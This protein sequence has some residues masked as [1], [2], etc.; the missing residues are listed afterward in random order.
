[1]VANY[2][3]ASQER[4]AFVGKQVSFQKGVVFMGKVRVAYNT[5]RFD[6]T[7]AWWTDGFGVECVEQWDN[8]HSRGAILSLGPGAELEIFAAAREAKPLKPPNDGFQIM[9]HSD[10]LR[11]DFARLQSKGVSIENPPMEKPWATQFTLRDPNGV[12][13]FIF[14]SKNK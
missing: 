12:Q 14:R 5:D 10:N 1:M 7:L 8:D 11:S 13:V 3:S 4:L 6:E 2:V 9:I